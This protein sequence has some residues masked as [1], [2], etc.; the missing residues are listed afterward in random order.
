MA[1]FSKIT[2]GLFV[3]DQTPRPLVIISLTS[4]AFY[5]RFQFSQKKLTAKTDNVRLLCSLAGST[6]R[7]PFYESKKMT[8]MC[9]NQTFVKILNIHNQLSMPNTLG[10]LQT[11]TGCRKGVGTIFLCLRATGETK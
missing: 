2:I 4:V 10:H 5:F 6:S 8:K 7:S 9:P 11:S 1:V 3:T